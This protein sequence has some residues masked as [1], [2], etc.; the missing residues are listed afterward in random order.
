MHNISISWQKDFTKDIRN[1]AFNKWRNF[2]YLSVDT[3]RDKGK[4]DMKLSFVFS[5]LPHTDT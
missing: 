4:S 3:S 1:V 2:W 5:G